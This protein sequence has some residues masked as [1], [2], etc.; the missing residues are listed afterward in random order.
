MGHVGAGRLAAARTVF[1]RPIWSAR[2]PLSPFWYSEMS[3]YTPFSWYCRSSP[4][5]SGSSSCAPRRA[6]AP[7]ADMRSTLPRCTVCYTQHIDRN[8]P[9]E[10]CGWVRNAWVGLAAHAAPKR[11]HNTQGC[12]GSR[13][14][15]VLSAAAPGPFF[16]APPAPLPPAFR[17]PPTCA[18]PASASVRASIALIC[19]LQAQPHDCSAHLLAC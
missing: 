8:T 11:Q 3:H 5:I 16:R 18:S 12:S 17:L 10:A 13:R 2:M 1:P 6:G 4:S 15:C 19:S 9:L 7:L 14:T